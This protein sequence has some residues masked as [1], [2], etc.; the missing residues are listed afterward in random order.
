MY[1]K[2]KWV[3]LT[4]AMLK[5]DPEIAQEILNLITTAYSKIGG[6]FKFRTVDDLGKAT[7]FVQAADID[8]DPNADATMLGKTTPK[9][10]KITGMGHDDSSAGKKSALALT[11]KSLKKSGFYAEV[12]GAMAHILINKHGMK[13]I[14]NQAEVE[15]IVGAKVKWLG[16]GWYERRI[17][18]Q[19]A[20]KAL[21]GHPKG[22]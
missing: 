18:G 13:P 12:S 2:R 3:Q 11:V 4:P 20:K 22:S 16:N 1:P 21:I 7:L 5:G 19:L 8:K 6:H 17:G 9:G 15:N 10:V 14:N